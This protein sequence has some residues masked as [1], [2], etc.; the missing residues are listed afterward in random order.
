[1][2]DLQIGL[3]A[4]DDLGRF[5]PDAQR[6]ALAAIADAGIDHVFTADHVSFIDGSGIDGPV[7]LAALGAL[8]PRLG[9]HLGV[10]LLALRHPLVAARQIATLAEYAPGRVSIGVGVGGEDRHEF[11]VCEVDPATRG[12]R[13]DVELDIVRRLLDGETV[14]G[15]GEFFSF[16]QAQIRPIPRERIPFVV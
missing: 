14:D 15:D 5:D 2:S 10:M 4:P 9:L 13:T 6:A 16:E 11:E 12:R 3:S 7:R 1:M 8:E